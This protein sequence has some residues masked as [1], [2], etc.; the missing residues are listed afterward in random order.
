MLTNAIKYAKHIFRMSLDFKTNF[1]RMTVVFHKH[2]VSHRKHVHIYSCCKTVLGQ[3]QY[4]L[5]VF[6]FFCKKM[7]IQMVLQR[8]GV[9]LQQIFF[10]QQI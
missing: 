2:K 6:H 3:L 7:D 8:P 10:L 4:H 1:V 5:D 9:F